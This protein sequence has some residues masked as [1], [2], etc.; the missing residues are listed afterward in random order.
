M[1][2]LD[3]SQPHTLHA[4]FADDSVAGAEVLA[5]CGPPVV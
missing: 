3:D 1:K 5:V 2:A 4:E